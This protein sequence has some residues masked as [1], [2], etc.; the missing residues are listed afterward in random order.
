M[1]ASGTNI[2][3]FISGSKKTFIIPPFQRNYTW[4]IEEAKTLWDDFI[5]VIHNNRKHYLGNVTYYLGAHSGAVQQDL[6]LIDG[7]QRVT[8]LLV[9]MAAIRDLSN[10]KDFVDDI[11]DNYFYTGRKKEYHARLHQVSYD[12]EAFKTIVERGNLEGENIKDSNLVKNYILFKSLVERSGMDSEDLF[13]ELG[14]MELVE[15]N[16]QAENDLNVVQT[17]FEKINS[18]GKPLT[19]S[20]LIRNYLLISK[21]EEDQEHLYDNYWV[22]IEENLRDLNLTDFERFF[23]VLQTKSDADSKKI[24]P[25]FKSTYQFGESDESRESVLQQMLVYSNVYRQ[26]K[27]NETANKVLRNAIRVSEYVVIKEWTPFLMLA[28]LKLWEENPEEL[29]KIIML[30]NHYTIRRRTIGVT[31][32]GGAAMALNISLLSKV[33]DNELQLTHDAVLFELSNAETNTQRF[34]ADDEFEEA[35]RSRMMRVDQ[36][37]NILMLIEENQS[38]NIPVDWKEV[39][40][41]HLMP[42]KLNEYWVADLGGGDYAN[43]VHEEYLNNFGN[44]TPV[45]RGYNSKMSNNSWAVKRG[46][47]EDIQFE[48]TK[49]VSSQTIWGPEQIKNRNKA[50]VESALSVIEGPLQRTRTASGVFDNGLYPA[51]DLDTDMGKTKLKYVLVDDTKIEVRNWNEYF[52]KVAELLQDREPEFFN[53]VVSA[54]RIHKTTSTK[55][56]GEKDP[57]ITVNEELLVSPMPIS[58]TNYFTEGSLSSGSARKQV[59]SLLEQ[60]DIE[61]SDVQIY[62]EKN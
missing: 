62:V 8:T 47:L 11:N 1:E 21:T 38:L 49:K 30:L 16:L 12:A 56:E 43:V 27:R 40:I 54:N 29:G 19:P 32:G 31:T 59:L 42:Q 58:G 44:L 3:E 51:D 53:V 5:D 28:S 15:V 60:F 7:Q 61:P 17:I 46:T 33:L 2:L 57:F 50:L 36:A 10:D 22:P 18:T 45:S 4:T 26:I 14:R 41:E 34:P 25:K 55:I 35:L 37:K 24:Y 48:I 39:T 6:I 13:D 20:D 52:N 23:L 9:L